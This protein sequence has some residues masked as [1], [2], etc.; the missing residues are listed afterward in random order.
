MYGKAHG[1]SQ[2]RQAGSE[3]MLV[4]RILILA[5]LA[6]LVAVFIPVSTSVKAAGP[7]VFPVMNTSEQ[8]PD[9][10]WFRNSPTLSDTNEVT[11]DGVYAGDSVQLNCYAYGSPV[12]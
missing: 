4:R 5:A 10:V 8:L 2:R 6:V 9:G 11:G 12:G 1:P 7:P 3:I